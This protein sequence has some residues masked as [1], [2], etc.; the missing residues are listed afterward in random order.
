MTL[1]SMTN[2]LN[3]AMEL[4]WTMEATVMALAVGVADHV[5]VELYGQTG[6]GQQT[7][8][9]TLPSLYLSV[10]IDVAIRQVTPMNECSHER[11]SH[12]PWK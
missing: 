7:R 12:V 3:G 11:S 1:P 10:A 5:C 8:A 9:G 2:L 4:V 6:R